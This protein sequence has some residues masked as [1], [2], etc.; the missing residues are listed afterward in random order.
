MA[1]RRSRTEELFAGPGG[2]LGASV[3]AEGGFDCYVVDPTVG[4]D[5]LPWDPQTA[6]VARYD[7]SGDDHRSLT[8][9]TEPLASDLSIRGA[10]EAVVHLRSDAPELPLS[11][12]LS[13]VS[14]N[15]SANLVCQGWV[16]ASRAAGKPLSPGRTYELRVPLYST[17]YRVGAGHRLR[18]GIAGSNF[19][20]LWGAAGSPA[21]EVERSPGRATQLS[22][23]VSRPVKSRWPS[24]RSGRR[25]PSSRTPPRRAG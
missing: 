24:H 11:V 7:R 10:P 14:P 19:P 20:L 1:P 2:T 5:L 9:T 21:I 18:L 16:S 8:Y 23:P 4:I 15:G 6:H 22:L 25:T 3:A 17:A 12:W 13:D